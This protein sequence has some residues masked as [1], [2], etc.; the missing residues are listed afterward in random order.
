MKKGICFSVLVS[1]LLLFNNDKANAQCGE[2]GFSF[3]CS[4]YAYDI[5]ERVTKLDDWVTSNSAFTISVT[6]E[7]ADIGDAYAWV[8]FGN[9]RW[10]KAISEGFY[11]DNFYAYGG[12][13]QS[14]H[15]YTTA[16]GGNASIAAAW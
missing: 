1:I 12:P 9:Y 2:T 6:L 11:E 8:V 10:A 14:I 3:Y 13:T 15:L 7:V 16:K 5:N 4:A